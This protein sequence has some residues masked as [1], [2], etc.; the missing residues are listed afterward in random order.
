MWLI[1]SR[2]CTL[3]WSANKA[4]NIKPIVKRHRLCFPLWSMWT[5]PKDHDKS[6]QA[7]PTLIWLEGKAQIMAPSDRLNL[8]WS[9]K[10]VPILSD[11]L[12]ACCKKV[13][14]KITLLMDITVFM[15]LTFYRRSP[16]HWNS[17]SFIFFYIY[18]KN[19]NH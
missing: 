5:K 7:F 9:A 10:G 11:I 19:V 1:C 16:W 3:Q 6:P 2:V 14:D 8:Y 12:L 17:A 15:K 13:H 18:K 4:W